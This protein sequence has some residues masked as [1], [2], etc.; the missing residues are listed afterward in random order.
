MPLNVR[1][2]QRWEEETYRILEELHAME[3]GAGDEIFQTRASP[4]E[5][6]STRNIAIDLSTAQGREARDGV[7]RHR[8]G[9][10]LPMEMPGASAS[11]T[12]IPDN[13]IDEIVSSFWEMAGQMFLVRLTRAE[14]WKL[15]A[16]IWKRA[17]DQFSDQLLRRLRPWFPNRWNYDC[18]IAQCIIGAVCEKYQLP[19]EDVYVDPN[20]QYVTLHHDDGNAT[21]C[22]AAWELAMITTYLA[23][24]SSELAAFLPFELMYVQAEIDPTIA[25]AF[26]AGHHYTA[27]WTM[28]PL[29]NNQHTKHYFDICYAHVVAFL[30][31]KDWFDGRWGGRER[32]YYDGFLMRLRYRLEIQ[33]AFSQE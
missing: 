23:V 33:G 17:D 4:F 24:L 7:T 1:P 22:Q 9:R 15:M 3:Q 31:G 16:N 6:S 13:L 2:T 28:G 30:D 14:L 25:E 27:D 21:R 12:D 18:W 20:S 8:L 19:R 26:M 11:A 10:L 5:D 32:L 29:M